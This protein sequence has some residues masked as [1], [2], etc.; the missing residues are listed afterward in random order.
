MKVLVTGANSLLGANVIAE[1]LR[2]DIAVRG[3]ARS[4][5]KIPLRHERLEAWTGRITEKS[6]VL[7]AVRGCDTVIH[8][9][10]CTDPGSL[11]YA[12]YT[13]VNVLGTRHI[14]EAAKTYGVK[15]VILVSS[16]NTLGYGTAEAPGTEAL[17]F[18]YPF[19]RSH[20]ARSKHA[21]QTWALQLPEQDRGD[22]IVVNPTFM[23]GAYDSR[24]SSG[25]IVLRGYKRKVV[26]VPPGG[27]N[28]I[29]VHDAAAAICNAL[30][31]GRNRECYLLANENMSYR[32]F[33]R[34]LN[35]VTHSRSL[36]ITLPRTVLLTAGA[37]GSLLARL[38]MRTALR[39]NNMRIL[40]VRNYYSSM[41]AVRELGLPQTPVREAISDAVAWFREA[42]MLKS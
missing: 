17:G 12:D 13:F 18:R 39:Y 32:E 25:A 30:T 29:H 10:A 7:S 28:F 40:C 33:Y 14:L 21:A 22:I 42:G 11:R 26:F 34:R 16:A 27:K 15:R 3:M 35:E 9:A 31:A 1:L 37:L 23:I 41:K 20:Y 5:K 6:E 19:T 24:P 4:A 36:I 38:G 8:I 2:R